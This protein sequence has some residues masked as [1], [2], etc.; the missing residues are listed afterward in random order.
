MAYME[1]RSLPPYMLPTISEHGSWTFA[2]TNMTLDFNSTHQQI[3]L[4]PEKHFL[5]LNNVQN[6]KNTKFKSTRENNLFPSHQKSM[7]GC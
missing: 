3:S 6:Q 2:N 5:K 7:E 1:G 4:T